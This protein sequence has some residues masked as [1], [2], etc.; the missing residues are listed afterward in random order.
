MANA[1]PFRFE[2]PLALTCA[3]GTDACFRNDETNRAY[4]YHRLE[5]AFMAQSETAFMA[6]SDNSCAVPVIPTVGVTLYCI[7]QRSV[8]PTAGVALYCI[9]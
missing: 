4:A 7:A 6:Q 1:A 2:I 5:T 8:I 3:F 9:A